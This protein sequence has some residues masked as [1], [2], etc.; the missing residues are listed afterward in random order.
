VAAEEAP[1]MIEKEFRARG[2]LLV[3]VP[4]YVKWDEY[5]WNQK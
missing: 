1:K 4:I 5:E 3:M 2:H